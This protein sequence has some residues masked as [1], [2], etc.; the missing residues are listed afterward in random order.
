MIY[1]AINGPYFLPQ[2][3]DYLFQKTTFQCIVLHYFINEPTP[4]T[5]VKRIHQLPD[6]LISQIKAGEV[7][8]RPASALKELIENA[9]DSGASNIKVR[10]EGGGLTLI[11]IEDDGSGIESEDLALAFARH[12]TSKISSFEDLSLATT[13]GFRGEALAS[14]G[15]VARVEII[16]KTAQAEYASSIVCEEGILSGI[17][18]AARSQGT[19]V[20]AR[21]LFF[22]V[23]ARRK[24]LKSPVT[25]F[26]HCKDAFLR[27]AF[28]RPDIAMTLMRDGKVIYKL[29][30]Q[31][32]GER[33]KAILGDEFSE[34]MIEVKSEKEPYT[35]TGFVSPV[36]NLPSGRETQYLFV[37]LRHTRDRLL[38][39]AAKEALSQSRSAGQEKEVSYVLF[40]SLPTTQVD[41]NAHPAKTEVRFRDPRAAHQF[42]LYSLMEAFKAMPQAPADDL[43]MDISLLE[44]SATDSWPG[45][46]MA[47][48]ESSPFTHRGDAL[49]GLDSDVDLFS[50]SQHSANG[51]DWQTSFTPQQASEMLH[52]SQTD[53]GLAFLDDTMPTA[54]SPSQ[55][56][57]D[58]LDRSSAISTSSESTPAF[59]MD[60][61]PEPASHLSEQAPRPLVQTPTS[62]PASQPSNALDSISSDRYLGRLKNGWCAWDC[63][64]GFWVTEPRALAAAPKSLDLFELAMNGEAVG[65]E[66]LIS[67]SIELTAQK[68]SSIKSYSRQLESLGISLQFTDTTIAVLSAPELLCEIDWHY[69][70]SRLAELITQGKTE[71][72]GIC[73]ALFQEASDSPAPD[74]TDHELLYAARTWAQHQRKARDLPGAYVLDFM[75]K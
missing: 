5:S 58:S 26:T 18:P 46:P 17:S 3:S 2:K 13:M 30:S 53:L 14:L 40:L 75:K 50:D 61:K 71:A 35:L 70:F 74:A 27:A 47:T 6:V 32:L 24:F 52:E 56:S 44:E 51:M 57:R 64:D 41:A 69:G 49:A 65:T 42:A 48:S 20:E 43:A 31:S 73:F 33:V 21:D 28:S 67:P 29:A 16:S 8:E 1:F 4:M 25:E 38:S 68:I 9:L 62:S 22:Y 39:H 72:L 60:I 23:P 63:S 12:A 34:K 15:S 59:M 19:T 7:I 10:I 11:A 55:I 36:A 45:Q 37:N 54:F 66:L